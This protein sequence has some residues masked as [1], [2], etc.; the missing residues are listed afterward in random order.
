MI[1]TSKLFNR[2]AILKSF[3]SKL[4]TSQITLDEIIEEDMIVNDIKYNNESEFIDF[5]TEDKIKQLIDYSTKIPESSDYNIGYKYPFNATE[6]LISENVKFQNKFLSQ[7]PLISKELKEKQIKNFKE[8]INKAKKII[9]KDGFFSKFFHILNEVRGIGDGARVGDGDGGPELNLEEINEDDFSEEEI[10]E[11]ENSKNREKIMVYENIDYLLNFLLDDNGAQENYVLMGYF[12]KIL[13]AIINIHGVKIIQYLYDFPKKNEF[14]ILSIFINHMNRKSMCDIVRKLLTFEDDLMIQY[15]E[16]KINL[17]EK[18][19]DELNLCND[20]DKCD[21]ICDAI[22]LILNNN[23]FFDLFMSKN[24]LLEKIYDIFYTCGKNKNIRKKIAMFKLL[25]K[26]NECILQHFEV[27]YTENPMNNNVE[28]NEFLYGS[29]ISKENNE[30]SQKNNNEKLLTNFLNNLFEIL[31]KNNFNDF[32]ELNSKKI[33]FISTYMQKQEKMG[34]L[35]L[36]QTEYFLSL[37]E[38]FVNSSG[39]KYH[40]KKIDELIDIMNQKGIFWNLH[41]M[42]FKYIYNNIYQN[43]YK[44]IIEII[45]NEHTPKKLI[46]FFFFEKENKNLSLINL[47]IEKEISED[48][49]IKNTS[50][51]IYTLNP[52]FGFI[53]SI[54][55]QIYTSQNAE[56]RKI[57]EENNDIHIFVE[58][59]VEEFEKFFQ[60]KLLY[61][62]P[63]DALCSNS[64]PEPS[65]F[66]NKNIFEIF[67]E[68]CEIYNTYKAGEDYKKLLKEKKE[69]LEQENNKEKMN[70]NIENN[71]GIKYIDDLEDE[72]DEEN[73]EFKENKIDLKKDRDNFLEM[74]NKPTDE[75]NKDINN[76]NINDIE[77]DTY[78]GRFNIDDLED[79]DEKEGNEIK[80]NEDITPDLNEN[81][82]HYVDYNK[83]EE[84]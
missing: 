73:P 84:K 80:I 23:N 57:L 35:K 61:Q 10:L 33:E 30:Y 65:P 15:Q 49:K 22:Y 2:D 81:K 6:I 19:L 17:L 45:I 47:Y 78:H 42:F 71:K 48:M 27:H 40:E 1:D 7:K 64:E 74:L 59:M 63:L 72:L 11:Y 82:I 66:G 4:K 53:N 13:N 50:K 62:D 70:E 69:K 29:N 9:K 3:M 24:F 56:I 79:E 32:I 55:Y 5:L 21:C 18:I 52:C 51:N 46:Q 38:I 41:E 77:N 75:V 8:K 67:E 25:I 39:A 44:R 83:I 37:I 20:E 36:R 16:K 76:E 28:L 14:D 34:F 68:N 60:Y 31:E 58:I 54:I 12:Y 26:I 43:I